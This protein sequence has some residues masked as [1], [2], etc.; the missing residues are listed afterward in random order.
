[1]FDHGLTCAKNKTSQNL[2][3]VRCSLCINRFT[4]V[5]ICSAIELDRKFTL[6]GKY[7][8]LKKLDL[9]DKAAGERDID[10]L[11]GT[12]YYLLNRL[13]GETNNGSNEFRIANSSKLGWRFEN[14][15]STYVKNV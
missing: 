10:L 15:Y 14:S 7:R 13:D 3:T 5:N 12:D 8:F 2:G 9:A 11:I 6:P 1:M 4:G